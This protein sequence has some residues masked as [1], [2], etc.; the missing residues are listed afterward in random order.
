ML[1]PGHIL[2]QQLR[3]IAEVQQ[4]LHAL[5]QPRQTHSQLMRIASVC[6]AFFC[7]FGR[8]QEGMFASP[9]RDVEQN[10]L[11]AKLRP[12]Q[13]GPAARVEKLCFPFVD[14][15]AASL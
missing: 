9:P 3:N 6:S 1:S 2:Q 11:L 15:N 13:V 7:R 14:V 8:S 4:S 12:G 10:I 5:C